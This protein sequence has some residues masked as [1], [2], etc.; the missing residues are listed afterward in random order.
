MDTAI[1]ACLIVMS[2]N[3]ASASVLRITWGQTIPSRLIFWAILG[4]LIGGQIGPRLADKVPDQ[5][6]K[7]IFIYGLSLVG[8]HILF[9]VW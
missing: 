7:E 1:G 8:I 5:T 6:L 2:I 4:V 9:N 3:A